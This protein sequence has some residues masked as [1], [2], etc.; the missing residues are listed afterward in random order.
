[1]ESNHE[2]MKSKILIEALSFL[3]VAEVKGKEDN[4][5]IIDMFISLGFTGF[6]DEV[7]WCAAYV[8]SVLKSCK[9]DYLMSLHA[10]DYTEYG[11]ATGT[12]QV[13]DIVVMWRGDVTGTAGHVAFF[14]HMDTKYVYVLGGNQSNTVSVQTYK[15]ERVLAFREAVLPA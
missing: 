1:M 5:K 11:K 6:K 3:G 15:R 12:P 7:P 14:L 13:G 9:L 2:I 10:R 8:G 4:Q